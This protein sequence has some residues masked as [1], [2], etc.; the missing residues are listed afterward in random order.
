MVPPHRRAGG[1]LEPAGRA[2]ELAERPQGEMEEK[3]R[4]RKRKITVRS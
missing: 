4:K 2:S 3:K 1:G